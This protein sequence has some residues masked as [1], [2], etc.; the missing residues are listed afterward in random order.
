M[1]IT[2]Y[3]SPGLRDSIPSLHDIRGCLESQEFRKHVILAYES[4]G[5]TEYLE[6]LARIVSAIHG[7]NITNIDRIFE[8]YEI[9][10]T[11]ER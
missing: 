8:S 1:K 6:N 9:I 2:L 4:L 5:H 7:H 11:E 10:N 3:Q